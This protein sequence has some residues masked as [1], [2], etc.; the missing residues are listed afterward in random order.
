MRLIIVF[1]ISMKVLYCITSY[2]QISDHTLWNICL[3]HKRLNWNTSLNTHMAA[4]RWEQ[5]RM[6]S[7]SHC[8][9]SAFLFVN[10]FFKPICSCLFGYYLIF[11]RRDVRA[12]TTALKAS[13]LPGATHL[14]GCRS[15]A[16]FL[17]ALLTSSL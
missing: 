12:L 11:F 15:T 17:Y 8:K 6:A 2:H 1:I 13:S 14:S 7:F 10:T 9:R 5:N 16:S 3:T 4:H